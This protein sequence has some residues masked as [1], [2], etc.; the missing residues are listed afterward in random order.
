MTHAALAGRERYIRVIRHILK[1]H[2]CWARPN[3]SASDNPARPCALARNPAPRF[4]VRT[5][6][7]ESMLKESLAAL[8]SG[9]R[10]EVVAL[11]TEEDEDAIDRSEK[12][13]MC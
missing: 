3:R 2:G 13:A 6:F 1:W 10:K 9:D 4:P 8:A 5:R 7:R 12:S 11:L